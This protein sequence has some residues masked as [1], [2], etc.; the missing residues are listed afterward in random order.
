[1]KSCV[2]QSFRT[3]EAD[4][5]SDLKAFDSAKEISCLTYHQQHARSHNKCSGSAILDLR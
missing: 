4:V 1:M 5:I 3:I 2:L